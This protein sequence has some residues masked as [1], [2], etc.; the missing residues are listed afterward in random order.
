[1]IMQPA[2]INSQLINDSMLRQALL[3]IDPVMTNQ[4]K[5]PGCNC[6]VMAFY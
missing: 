2:S 4:T 5:Y 1:M 6:V 3:S